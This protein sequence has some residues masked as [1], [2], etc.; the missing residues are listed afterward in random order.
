[1]RCVSFGDAFDRAAT[2]NTTN[3]ISVAASIPRSTRANVTPACFEGVN[4]VSANACTRAAAQPL[5]PFRRRSRAHRLEPDGDRA[6]EHGESELQ[7][8]PDRRH[9]WEL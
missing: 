1:M 4:V 7:E 6:A 9:D 8:A 5:A 3:A 2:I